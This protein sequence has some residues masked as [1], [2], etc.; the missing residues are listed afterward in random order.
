M[1]TIGSRLD[2]NRGQGKG[3]DGLRL[4]LALGVMCW[5]AFALTAPDWRAL[6]SASL[7]MLGY[8]ILPIFFGLSGFLVT[9]SALRNTLQQ[10][11][12]NR[13]FRIVP[14]L[15]VDTLVTILI[16]GP[17]LTDVPIAR[18]FAS[19]VTHAYLLNIVGEIHYYLPGVFT[20]NP[21]PGVVNGSLWTISPELGCYIL[22]GAL[23]AVRGVGDWRGTCGMLIA[24]VATWLLAHYYPWREHHVGIGWLQS[25][26]AYLI[27]LFLMGSLAFHLRDDIVYSRRLAA[28][29]L[30]VLALTGS[31]LDG[32]QVWSAPPFV[33]LTAPMLIYL[34]LFLGVTSLPRIGFYTTGDYSYGIY[35]YGFPLEQ[36]IIELSGWRSPWLVTA[37]AVPLTTLMAALSWHCVE[38]QAL[39]LRKHIARNNH[40]PIRPVQQPGTPFP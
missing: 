38:K 13:I 36:A 17:L 28:F 33:L 7:W 19:P 24:F 12:I 14:A 30:I 26:N 32:R 15:L 3:F 11:A 34:M 5:H 20:H 40:A 18:Y 29:C 27:P 25:P 8:A 39:R 31:L 37:A 4:G 22:I 35:L 6:N 9:G 10:F 1:Q 2:A 23:I 21:Y 16:L